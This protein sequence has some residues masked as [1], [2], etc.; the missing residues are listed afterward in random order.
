MGNP[1]LSRNESIILATHRI[2]HKS[3]SSDMILTNQRLILVD[4]NNPEFLPE[5]LPLT[6][7]ETVLP[8][9]S[10]S[11][12]PEITLSVTAPTGQGATVPMPLVFTERQGISRDTERDDWVRHLR[13][14]IALVREMVMNAG[15]VEESP[16]PGSPAG[17]GIPEA[18]SGSPVMGSPQSPETPAVPAVTPEAA[19]GQQPIPAE[20]GPVTIP[21]QGSAPVAGE[22]AAAETPAG[23]SPL[24]DRFHPAG[25]QP[26]GPRR[27]TVFVVAAIAVLILVIAGGSYV[28]MNGFP[29]KTQ[30]T[31]QPTPVPTT[32]PV[33]T[34]TTIPTPDAT[35]TPTQPVV[36]A[37]TV[38][39][40]Q[41][42]VPQTGVWAHVIY[43]GKFTGTVGT[44]GR[45]RDVSGSGDQYYQIP[46]KNEVVSVTIQKADGSGN[47]LSVELYSDGVMVAGK[48]TKVPKGTVDIH[49]TV[50]NG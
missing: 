33:A 6:T 43:S 11:G 24:A 36:A 29:G 5:T 14:Q 46:A 13:D 4:S 38:T 48:S 32:E 23:K 22:A 39:E 15:G 20:G 18:A 49:V 28:F 35:A 47:P 31:P 19:A 1:Y 7:I 21:E 17:S 26:A 44:S 42:F 30:I 41:V 16:V 37:T 10:A 40:P 45:F 9:E 8:G 25:Q 34:P 27:S 12:E 2:H 50:K 3:V